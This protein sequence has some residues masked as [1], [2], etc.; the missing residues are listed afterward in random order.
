MM[1]T[2]TCLIETGS[3]LIPKTH[4]DSH[5]AGQRRPVNSGKLLVACSRS[6]A[7]CQCSRY[8]K[9]FQSGMR[10]PSGQP[11]L[12]NGM[13]QSMQ[14]PAWLFKMEPSNGSYTSFQSFNRSSTGRRVGPLRPHFK[15]P[16][17][18]PTCCLHHSVICLFLCQPFGCRFCLHGKNSFVIAWHHFAE[19]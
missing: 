14:R 17:V 18:S 4:A 8:T 3:W 11:L 19:A 16:V 15:N 10:L 6:M 7:S 9:S 5:G 1:V 13:P 12:Q 2:S